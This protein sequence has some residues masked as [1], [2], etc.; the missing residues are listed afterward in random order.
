M[1]DIVV[2]REEVTEKELKLIVY[3][4]E[5]G[6]GSTIVFVQNGQP[7]RAEKGIQSEKF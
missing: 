1:A 7:V 2:K 3:L 6:Y 5:I 4:R